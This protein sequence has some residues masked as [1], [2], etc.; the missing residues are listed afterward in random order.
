ME[1]YYLFAGNLYYPGQGWQD[2]EGSFATIEDAL[3]HVFSLKLSADSWF[4]IVDGTN[5]AIVRQ[6]DREDE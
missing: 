3:L 5:G 6:G 2:F 4:Q 1:R